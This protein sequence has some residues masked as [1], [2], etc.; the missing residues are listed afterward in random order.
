MGSLPLATTIDIEAPQRKALLLSRT[1]G[2][3]STTAKSTLKVIDCNASFEDRHCVVVQMEKV[4]SIVFQGIVDMRVLSGTVS[5]YGYTATDKD[6]WLRLYSPSSHPLVQI[7][8]LQSNNKPIS[9]TPDDDIDPD[10]SQIHKILASRFSAETVDTKNSAV[11]LL[12]S[13]SCGLEDIGT[14]APPYRGLFSLKSLSERL[15]IKPSKGAVKRKLA[16]KASESNGI[17]RNKRHAGEASSQY[18]TSATASPLSSMDVDTAEETEVDNGVSQER[19]AKYMRQEELLLNA[20][21]LPNFYPVSH[22][23]PDLHLLQVPRD[24]SETLELASTSTIQLD[25]SFM[26]IS[27]MYVVAGDQGQGKSTFTR[28][29]ANRLVE[30][31]GRVFYMETDL[32]Q[33]ELAPPGSVSLSMVTGPLLGPPFTHV[34]QV[35]PYHAVYMGVISPKSGPDQYIAAIQRLTSVYRRYIHDN[36]RQ[37]QDNTAVSNQELDRQVVPL[38]VNTQGWLK[39]LGLDLHYSLCQTVCPTNYIQMYDTANISYEE[40]EE[41]ATSQY[42]GNSPTPII[43]F[44]SIDG[45]DPLLSWITSMSYDRAIQMLRTKSTS[46]LGR[47]S[48]S[49][50]KMVPKLAAQD[51]RTLSMIS[52]FHIC[53]GN[54]IG[55]PMWNMHSPLASLRPL[56]VPLRDVVIWIGEEDIPSSQLLRVLNGSVVGVIATSSAPTPKGYTWTEEQKAALFDSES[57]GI[58]DQAAKELSEPG[59][60]ILL[61]SKLKQEHM[62]YSQQLPQLV[63][64]QPKSSI[65]TFLT[66]AIVRSVD[67]IEGTVHLLLPKLYADSMTTTQQRVVVGLAKGP[68]PSHQGIEMPAWLLVDGGYAERA[69]GSSSVQRSGRFSNKRRVIDEAEDNG[70]VSIGIQEAPYLSVEVDEGIGAS[71]ARSKGGFMRRGLEL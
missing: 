70:P 11:V 31:Y 13:V 29:L 24:W 63:H 12:R 38:L 59:S 27:P 43:D 35:E 44:T 45:C 3:N 60:R 19:V 58:C 66:H 51:M 17:S 2:S 4:Q 67:P 68:G 52:S 23:T 53:G 33:S 21:G 71:T 9:S 20:I 56:A 6:Q 50:T 8:A 30:R 25:D 36:L 28:M 55:P 65:T 5:V 42:G 41:T 54:L 48:E 10:I 34:G 69:M 61:R 22:M 62:D 64:G 37:Y 18:T 26:P 7:Q 40:E 47:D 1:K 14:V 39:G 16:L 32:G 49:N 15:D 57:K 46:L